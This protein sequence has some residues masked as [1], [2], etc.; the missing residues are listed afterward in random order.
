MPSIKHFFAVDLGATSGRTVLGTLS[1]GHVTLEELTRFPNHLIEATGHC[2]WDILALYR[3]TVE[4][5]RLVARRGTPIESVGID[6]WGCDFVFLGDDGQLLRYP[7]AYRDPHTSGTME[8]YFERNFTREQVYGTTGIQFLPFNSLFQ[9]YQMHEDGDAALRHADKVLFIPDALTY[10]LTGQ[11]VCEYTVASTSQLLNPRTGDLDDRLVESVGLHR[12][13]FG[14]M[15]RPGTIVGTLSP[16]VRQ[17]TGLGAVPVVAV[18][19]HDTASAVAAVPAS[20]PRFAYLS[21]G[22]WSLMGIESPTPIINKDSFDRNFTNEGGVEGTTRFLKNICGMWIYERCRAEWLAG[23]PQ[24]KTKNGEGET[25][26]GASDPFSH[27]TLQ[28]AA[29]REEAGR[30]LINPDDPCFANPASMLRAIDDYCRRHGQ[31][32]PATP[33]QYCRC[34]F[35]SLA[36][37]YAE[38]FGWLRS[39][40]PFPIDTLHIIGG[41]AMNEYLDQ[42]TADACGV[43]VLAGPQEG[44]A[45]GNVMLQAKAAGAVGDL[46]QMR[47]IIA[48]SVQPKRFEPRR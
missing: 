30:S 35:D 10:M 29:M 9:L 38:V 45:L 34:I 7:L 3:E 28:A 15:V 33:A 12:S 20:S 22:T 16:Q 43:T 27:A 21:S 23:S 44:T 46:W 2:Y 19:G 37:R 1:D 24:R 5:L 26:D 17:M 14:R 32:V 25:Q 6:T 41:G 18:A 48:D 47:R 31:P 36:H 8:R 13:R 11:T 42:M 40:A 39:M 4:G